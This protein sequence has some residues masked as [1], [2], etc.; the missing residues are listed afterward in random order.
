[1]NAASSLPEAIIRLKAGPVID[2]SGKA[3]W[4]AIERRSGVSGLTVSGS[5]FF[6]V[7]HLGLPGC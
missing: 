3:S 4:A 1:M 7:D 6:T 2:P 5:G